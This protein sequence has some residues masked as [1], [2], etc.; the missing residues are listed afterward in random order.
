[1]SGQS[2]FQSSQDMS[3]L[4]AQSGKIASNAAKRFG[5]V[6]VSRMM[7]TSVADV[8]AAG[9]CVETWH[10]LLQRPTYL[11]LGTTAHK[12]GRIAG[13]TVVGGERLFPG[14]LGTQV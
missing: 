13:E 11:P 6:R 5:A 14:T 8:F 10:R 3:A 7:A 2:Q 4:F 12:Q 1:M 9:D